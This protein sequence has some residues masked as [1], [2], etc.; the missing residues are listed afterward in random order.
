VLVLEPF[1]E[2]RQ[3]VDL[4]LFEVD[5]GSAGVEEFEG[6]VESPLESAHELAADDDDAAFFALHG[7]DEHTARNV[8]RVLDEVEDLGDH[9]V[10]RVQNLL[11]L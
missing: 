3:L 11:L 8:G 4:V 6:F 10:A 9:L 7:V 5:V 2:L 1:L